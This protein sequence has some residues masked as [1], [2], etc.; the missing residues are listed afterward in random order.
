MNLPLYLTRWFTCYKVNIEDIA[1]VA[2]MWVLSFT[3]IT[4]CCLTS[5]SLGR[6]IMVYSDIT[7]TGIESTSETL[8]FTVPNVG[9]FYVLVLH[10]R[11]SIV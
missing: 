4:H 7:H 10:N 11:L 1:G 8:F 3:N 5:A 2:D 6:S 9:H